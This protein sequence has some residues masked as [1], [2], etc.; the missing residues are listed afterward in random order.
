VQRACAGRGLSTIH[1]AAGRFLSL[2]AGTGA[3]GCRPK[4]APAVSSMRSSEFGVRNVNNA[5]FALPAYR[6]RRSLKRHSAFRIRHSEFRSRFVSRNCRRD[7]R[8]SVRGQ[9]V[10]ARFVGRRGGN[11]R[12]PFRF[13]PL[14]EGAHGSVSKARKAIAGPKWC[15]VARLLQSPRLR[16]FRRF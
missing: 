8:Y 13:V 9:D 7:G 3:R 16:P 1:F 11:T 12:R 2:T 4:T 15:P 14:F 5:G 10:R 6:R